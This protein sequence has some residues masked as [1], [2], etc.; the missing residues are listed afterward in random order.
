MQ[1]CPHQSIGAN[2]CGCDPVIRWV[3]HCSSHDPYMSTALKQ[4][5]SQWSVVCALRHCWVPSTKCHAPR[6]I[7]EV[8]SKTNNLQVSPHCRL[9][10]ILD[11]LLV[12]VTLT[13]VSFCLFSSWSV[14][15]TGLHLV[16]LAR[17]I[18]WHNFGGSCAHLGY[19]V[20]HSYFC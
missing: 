12:S 11:C 14:F 8:Y 9:V 3:S 7:R 18:G 2:P 5:E 10:Y 13:S 6:G 15:H 19:F 16:C 1:Y 20:R 17:I 4:L